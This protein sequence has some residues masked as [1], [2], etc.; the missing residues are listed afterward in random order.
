LYGIVDNS[1]QFVELQF[2][3]P[4]CLS[5]MTMMLYLEMWYCKDRYQN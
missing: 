3:F 4:P 5:E 1:Q 2:T